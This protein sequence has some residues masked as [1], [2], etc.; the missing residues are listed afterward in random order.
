[1][2]LESIYHSHS[3]ERLTDIIKNTP[4]FSEVIIGAPK[5]GSDDVGASK[6]K[7]RSATSRGFGERAGGAINVQRRNVGVRMSNN[8]NVLLFVVF[9]TKDF[10]TRR[11]HEMQPLARQTG[12]RL[13]RIVR[14]LLG[15]P[16]LYDLSG[17]WTAEEEWR[18]W[19]DRPTSGTV[20]VS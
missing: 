12:D 17:V 7:P 10:A 4:I 19:S 5:S 1:M 9:F 3:T 2:D 20:E 13:V 14:R 11:V 15:G 6:A 8:L 18:H 16:T